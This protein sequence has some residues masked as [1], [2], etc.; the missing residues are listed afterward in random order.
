[1]N[2]AMSRKPLPREWTPEQVAQVFYPP[3]GGDDRGDHLI[4]NVSREILTALF[5]HEKRATGCGAP[6]TYAALASR[7]REHVEVSS[8]FREVISQ[9]NPWLADFLSAGH[10]SATF[11]CQLA[12]ALS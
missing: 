3:I 10:L 9:E 1:M 6:Y 8:D 12:S 4:H 7:A 2:H 5:S 11:R